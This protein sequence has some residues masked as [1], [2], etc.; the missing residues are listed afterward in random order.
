MDLPL[1]E[2]L[3]L[4]LSSSAVTDEPPDA[5]TVEWSSKSTNRQLGEQVNF[6]IKSVPT[7]LVCST[8]YPFAPPNSCSIEDVAHHEFTAL[9]SWNV[10]CPTLLQHITGGRRWGCVETE[11]TGGL[12]WAG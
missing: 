8:T 12:G 11:A 4:C 10:L 1:D 7:C 9:L 6:L 5:D 3:C 2:G